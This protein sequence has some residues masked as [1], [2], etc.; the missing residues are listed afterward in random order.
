LLAAIGFF[1]GNNLFCFHL[2]IVQASR[3]YADVPGQRDPKIKVIK[4]I[5]FDLCIL[6]CDEQKKIWK[7]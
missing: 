7:S 2:M 5:G 6:F 4:Y 3:N 1:G